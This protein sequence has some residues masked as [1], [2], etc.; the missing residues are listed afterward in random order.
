MFIFKCLFL[1]LVFV[2]HNKDVLV[3]SNG[4]TPIKSIFS[5]PKFPTV[6]VKRRKNSINRSRRRENFTQNFAP[7]TRNQ[8]RRKF[9]TE[10]AFSISVILL[11]SVFA[12]Y[13][14]FS[15]WTLVEWAAELPLL[16]TYAKLGRMFKQSLN[17]T[18]VVK[19]SLLKM[20]LRFFNSSLWLLHLTLLRLCRSYQLKYEQQR[21]R[22][23]TSRSNTPSI[24]PERFTKR[25]WYSQSQSSL[26]IIYF[27]LC[28]FQ[29]SFLLIHFCYGPSIVW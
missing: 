16:K 5:R 15:W 3:A 21:R 17:D 24:L 27:R 28:G 26:L 2:G 29:S 11:Y 22:T 6:V 19:R 8:A 23:G 7:R 14:N 25:V 13:I 18:T 12:E 9:A 1:F 10:H 20:N 4:S